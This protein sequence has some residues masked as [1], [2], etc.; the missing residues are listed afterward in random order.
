MQKFHLLENA[1][2]GEIAS[3]ISVLNASEPNYLVA[4]DLLQRRCKKP[5]QIVQSHL[6]SLFELP[7]VTRDAPANLRSLAE[8]AQMHVKAL[9][10]LGQ[11]IGL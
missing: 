4:W 1:L 6:K 3:V 2:R 7:E 5:R 8:Q 9:A 11:P 10:T